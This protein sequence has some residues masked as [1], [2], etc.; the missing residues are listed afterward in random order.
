MSKLRPQ[1]GGYINSISL[2]FNPNDADAL[3]E[4][5]LDYT[6]LTP[7]P[8]YDCAYLHIGIAFWDN[9]QL[10]VADID[11]LSDDA[12]EIFDKLDAAATF[13]DW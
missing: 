9:F 10:P 2:R 13:C 12:Q 7:D 8:I 1:G 6:D 5:G 3:R 11:D 4:I